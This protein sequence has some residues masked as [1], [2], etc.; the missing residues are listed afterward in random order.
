MHELGLYSSGLSI[1]PKNGFTSAF[2]QSSF[3]PRSMEGPG[4]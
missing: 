2:K 3:P 1:I 4:P